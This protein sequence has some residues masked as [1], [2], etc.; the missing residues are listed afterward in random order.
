[1]KFRIAAAAALII[2]SL[3]GCGNSRDTSSSLYTPAPITPR[4]TF[5][6]SKY[7][8]KEEMTAKQDKDFVIKEDESISVGPYQDRSNEYTLIT[9][10]PS[11]EPKEKISAV[12]ESGSK[13]YTTVLKNNNASSSGNTSSNNIVWTSQSSGNSSSAAVVYTPAPESTPTPVLT[14]RPSYAV[15]AGFSSKDYPYKIYSNNGST[16][17]GKVTTNTEDPESIWNPNGE[18]GSSTSTTSIYNT[19]GIYGSK[20]SMFSAFNDYATAPPKIFDNSGNFVGYLSSNL[21]HTNGIAP[22]GLKAYAEK[23]GF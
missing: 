22:D 2:C 8:T 9:P 21:I 14:P 15:P 16:Y 20:N 11:P 4:P 12:S 6:T 10:S 7:R 5:D 13:A 17:L 1:M 18:Y 23:N 3:Y 19:Y